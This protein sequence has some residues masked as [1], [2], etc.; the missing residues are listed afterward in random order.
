MMEREVDFIKQQPVVLGEDGEA[1]MNKIQ[2][3]ARESGCKPADILRMIEDCCKD[4][5][6]RAMLR[7]LSQDLEKGREAERT[8]QLAAM[9]AEVSK[10]KLANR[11]KDMASMMRGREALSAQLGESRPTRTGA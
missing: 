10:L 8:T 4:L 6:N 9:E 2:E 1:A 7:E 5:G 11:Q 3:K